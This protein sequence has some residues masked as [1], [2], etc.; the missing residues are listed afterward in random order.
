MAA[1]END[2]KFKRRG[3]NENR[4]GKKGKIKRKNVIGGK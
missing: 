4:Q 3:I 2:E 1:R